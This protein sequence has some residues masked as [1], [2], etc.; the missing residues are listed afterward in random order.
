MAGPCRGCRS[1]ARA[2]NAP[3]GHAGASLESCCEPLSMSV[4]MPRQKSTHVDDPRAVGGRLRAARE[5][6]GLSQRAARVHRLLARLHLEDRVGRPDSL[7]PAPTRAGPPA[8]RL[9]GLSRQRRRPPRARRRCLEAE[10]ALRLGELELAEGVYARMARGGVPTTRSRRTRTRA[11]ARSRT[12]GATHGSRSSSSRARSTSDGNCGRTPRPRR[13]A[14]AR[15]RD[16]RRARVGDRRLR[17]LAGGG[18]GERD[19]QLERI[20]FRCSWAMR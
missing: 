1:R 16:G 18:G 9:R 7:A 8:R 12:A 15:V 4:Q 13:L 19:D 20:R 2:A 10:V 5:A 3:A 17:A 11:L 14:R 6:A